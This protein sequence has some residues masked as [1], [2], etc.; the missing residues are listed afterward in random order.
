MRE[1]F[2]AIGLSALKFLGQTMFDAFWR[3]TME[4]VIEYERQW[5]ET[6]AGEKRKKFVLEEVTIFLRARRIGNW[7]T[8]RWALRFIEQFIDDSI[9][10]LNDKLGHCWVEKTEEARK[11]IMSRVPIFN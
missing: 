1:Y 9:D 10:E 2:I 8:R 4:S 6:G 11:I 5:K 7:F 3:Q